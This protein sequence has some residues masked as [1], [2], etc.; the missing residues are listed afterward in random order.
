[1][2]LAL[3]LAPVFFMLAACSGTAPEEAL[4]RDV[5]AMRAAVEA[6]DAGA[7]S[8]GLAEDF[9]GPQGMDREAARR[10]AQVVFLRNRKV[11]VTL[12]PLDV[13]MREGGATVRFTAALTGDKS[14]LKEMNQ[15]LR[16][17]IV[18]G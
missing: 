4:R 18:T 5:D 15:A 1:M 8:D 2:R 16:A 12:G 10:L 13:A 3:V 17:C 11:G 7:V 14:T 6:R 9:I